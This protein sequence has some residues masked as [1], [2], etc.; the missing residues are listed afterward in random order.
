MNIS[1]Q[2][3]TTFKGLTPSSKKAILD[4]IKELA[5]TGK[6]SESVSARNAMKRLSSCSDNYNVVFTSDAIILNSKT[7]GCKGKEIVRGFFTDTPLDEFLRKAT[8]YI[9][10]DKLNSLKTSGKKGF[11][12]RAF[13]K[14]MK[15]LSK[16]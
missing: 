6:Y 15:K 10:K 11:L 4:E 16:I 14:I 3:K 8:Q 2:Q 1:I 13:I 9:E 5:K 7:N 12:R